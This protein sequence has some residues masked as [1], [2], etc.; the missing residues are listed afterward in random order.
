MP[1]PENLDER[2]R[3]VERALTDGDH[4]LT[5]IQDAADHHARFEDLDERLAAVEDR[6]VNLEAAVQALRGYVGNVRAVNREVERRADAAL[7][8]VESLDETDA[9][10]PAPIYPPP[11]RPDAGG[12]TDG[13]DE[14]DLLDR[15]RE[16]V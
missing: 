2:L 4:D 16:I 10:D 8:A 12:D 15:F 1:Q 13:T 9:I 7:A 3:A 5:E 6:L 11:E 14:P